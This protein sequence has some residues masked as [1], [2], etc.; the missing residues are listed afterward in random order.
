[1]RSGGPANRPRVPENLSGPAL[2]RRGSPR[3]PLSPSRTLLSLPKAPLPANKRFPSTALPTRTQPCPCRISPRRA[4]AATHTM[5]GGVCVYTRVWTHTYTRTWTRKF[6]MC[7]HTG[8]IPPSSGRGSA[9]GRAA[10]G[11]RRR[12]ETPSIHP[13]IHLSIHPIHDAGSSIRRRR[14]APAG[15][16]R[17][18]GRAG[19]GVAPAAVHPDA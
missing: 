15:A 4:R 6:S 18:R 9:A 13:C 19:G 3:P 16:R 10:A 14:R 7:L 1:M 11:A 12:R 17:R 2:C 8:D 5:A